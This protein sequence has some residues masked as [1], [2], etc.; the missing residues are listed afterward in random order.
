MSWMD[1]SPENF[2]EDSELEEQKVNSRL[3]LP[4]RAYIDMFICRHHL[5][6]KKYATANDVCLRNPARLGEKCR[7]AHRLGILALS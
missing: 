2:A 1:N 4:L 3:E 5:R 7:K 6:S